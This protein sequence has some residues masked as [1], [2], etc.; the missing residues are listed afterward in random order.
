MIESI[1]LDILLILIML[2]MMAIGAYRGG[3]REAFSAAGV[4]L[5]VLLAQ[6]W[7]RF[8]GGWIGQNTNL[9]DGGGQLT[10]S[11]ALLI[12]AALSVGYGVGTAFN[13]HPGPG[14]RMFGVVLAAGG[15]VV[16][17]SYVLTWLRVYVFNGVEP[18]IV[19][20]TYLARY[21]D[22][23]AG[24]VLLIV[25]GAIIGSALFGSIVRE[26][27]DE[28][29][30]DEQLPVAGHRRS[31]NVMPAPDKV[32]PREDQRHQSSPVQV[33]SPKQWEDRAGDLPSSRDS[34]W[35]NT[36]PSDAPGVPGDDRPSQ[37]GQVQQARNRRRGRQDDDES[38]KG[39][40]R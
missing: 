32:E 36:W 38:P 13:Y 25:S 8:W 24:L 1:F 10:V 18:E 11:V 6:E 40:R 14:G 37:V 15:A 39:S 5:G 22:G 29:M 7:S 35:S 20:D 31:A 34:Q 4:V 30:A 2:L 19:G 9:S 3:M 33:R 23:D 21:L 28:Q 12:V 17:I 16:A 26:R 27:D